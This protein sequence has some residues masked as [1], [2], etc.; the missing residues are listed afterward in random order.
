ML[1]AG[2]L[3]CSALSS[4]ARGA[5]CG[6]HDPPAGRPDPGRVGVLPSTGTHGQA[7]IVADL[8]HAGP[9]GRVRTLGIIFAASGMVAAGSLSSGCTGDTWGF[10]LP[11]GITP[12]PTPLAGLSCLLQNKAWMKEQITT[13][14]TEA[15]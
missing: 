13:T 9:S 10:C 5:R 11:G 6:S 8:Q 2:R 12:S 4:P 7:E 14:G 15:T 1:D 3:A